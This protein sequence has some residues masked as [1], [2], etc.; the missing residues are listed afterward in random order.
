MIF[1]VPSNPDHF[2]ILWCDFY[3][4]P[5]MSTFSAKDFKISNPRQHAE[6]QGGYAVPW[7]SD[8]LLDN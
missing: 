3:S 7:S 4:L 1:K 8:H 5:N 2:M 6:Q